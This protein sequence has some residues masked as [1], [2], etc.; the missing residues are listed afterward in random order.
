MR[1][2]RQST[3]VPKTSNVSALTCSMAMVMS[4]SVTVTSVLV[5]RGERKYGRAAL[6]C[7]ER[8]E[9]R[10]RR[11]RHGRARLVGDL[12]P[13]GPR[14]GHYRGGQGPVEELP[15]GDPTHG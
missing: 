2:D 12:R 8:G 3:T 9:K 14:G 6:T 15:P 4:S 5:V 7:L 10:R 1:L 11:P 13:C